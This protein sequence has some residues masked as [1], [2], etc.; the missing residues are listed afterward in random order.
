MRKTL[1]KRRSVALLAAFIAVA[2]IAAYSVSAA[3]AN[4]REPAGSF[5][6]HLV[7]GSG[8]PSG[9]CI[10]LTFDEQTVQ[11]FAN[12]PGQIS[13]RP[14][15]YSLSVTDNSNNHNF[16]LSGP[17]GVETE[18]T[19]VPN[20]STAVIDQT[21]KLHLKHGSYL[22]LCTSQIG[23]NHA[24]AGMRINIDVGGVGQVG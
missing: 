21:V 8:L 7:P 10:Q 24:A 6:S 17:D 9:L 15:N 14:G 22:L 16:A 3:M 13:L 23:V 2:A 4:G 18:I 20:G 12:S 11:G 5:C 19:P 1:F